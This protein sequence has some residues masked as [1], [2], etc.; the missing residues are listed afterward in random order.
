MTLLVR[1]AVLTLVLA[2][3]AIPTSA[4]TGRDAAEAT[5]RVGPPQLINIEMASA[6]CG[7]GKRAVAG[8]FELRKLPVASGPGTLV[9][10]HSLRH[11]QRAWDAVAWYVSGDEGRVVSRVYC[12]PAAG[13]RTKI[14][15]ASRRVSIPGGST[16]AVTQ[17]CP[18]RRH[19]AISGGF[20]A[21][22]FSPDLDRMP[23]TY[24]SRRIKR[25]RWRIVAF[26]AGAAEAVVRVQVYC[27][28][29][30]RIQ[31]RRATTIVDAVEGSVRGSVAA[32]CP[33]GTQAL[34]GGF[35]A[36]RTA[37]VLSNGPLITGSSKSGKRQWRVSAIDSGVRGRLTAYAYCG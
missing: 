15:T 13:S 22:T 7:Q 8:G 36:S 12:E 1:A 37:D 19:V 16:R 9:I 21:P 5:P 24:V 25:H 29:S 31:A 30:E 26:N 10:I 35:S 20:S 17:R 3:A 18:S 32:V 11:R 28:R 6:F 14:R 34:S 33:R 27:R 2:G 23:V 4:G